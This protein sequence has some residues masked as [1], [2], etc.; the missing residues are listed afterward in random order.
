MVTDM[1]KQ[2]TPAVMQEKVN[3]D[4]DVMP[5]YIHRTT[6]SKYLTL[7]RG[8]HFHEDI[9][10]FYV[11]S[12]HCTYFI[13][14]QLCRMEAGEG[15]FVNSGHFHNGFSEDDTDCEFIC[16]LLNPFV[17]SIT[18]DLARNYLE[19]LLQNN[20][21]PYQ[22]LSREVPWQASILDLLDRL[23]TTYM[24]KAPGYALELQS[25]FYTIWQLLFQNMPQPEKGKEREV[26]AKLCALRQMVSYVQ[27]NLTEKM[28]LEKIAAAGHLCTSACCRLFQKYM[29]RSPMAF[30][31]EYRL[32]KSR[33]LLRE[34]DLSITEVAFRLGFA[35]A[36]YYSEQFRKQYNC[37]P[38]Q[39]RSS[40]RGLR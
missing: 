14:G 19:P 40:V 32:E 24:Y 18:A 30:V 4:Y 9:E 15:I 3:Y 39:Y 17:L 33:E 27:D 20:A 16:V 8:C 7:N 38:R 1:S 28:T 29:Q 25:C 5:L 6:L 21:F 23:H 11:L 22:H 34:T 36:S 13:N 12:G 37:T 2:T 10:F 26:S 35:G 31:N